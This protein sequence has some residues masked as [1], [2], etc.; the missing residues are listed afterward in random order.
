DGYQGVTLGIVGLGRIGARVAQLMRPWNI[1]ILAHDPYIP[2]HRFLEFGAQP[3]DLDTLLR[4]SDVV[5]LHVVLT[6]E[7]RHMV[8]TRELPVH[9]FNREAIPRWLERFGGKAIL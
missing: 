7:T 6:K 3:T 1:T 2:P 8:S 4:Q 5:T 9:I